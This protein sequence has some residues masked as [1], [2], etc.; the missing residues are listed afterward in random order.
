MT[1]KH[2]VACDVVQSDSAAADERLGA[3][4]PL[5]LR[6][7][8]GQRA[9][10]ESLGLLD[11]EDVVQLDDGS[12]PLDPFEL[13]AALV[14]EHRVAVVVSGGQ[15]L[16]LL[17]VHDGRALLALADVSAGLLESGGSRPSA[18]RR[19]HA[20]ARSWRG[21]RRYR[22]DRL[23]PLPKLYGMIRSPGFHGFCHGAVPSLSAWM[24]RSANC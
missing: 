10:L 6:D 8:L 13:L 17:D 23:R 5:P 2:P 12:L 9:Q 1:L 7:R 18:G 20:P 22:R 21:R 3:L 11:V 16:P 4:V 24:I 14:I 15:L 19:S